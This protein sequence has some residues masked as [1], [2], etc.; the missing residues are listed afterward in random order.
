[1]GD[2]LHHQVLSAQALKVYLTSKPTDTSNRLQSNEQRIL[3]RSAILPAKA[4]FLDPCQKAFTLFPLEKE[5]LRAPIRRQRQMLY[6]NP[7]MGD[8]ESM[9]N[10][11]TYHWEYS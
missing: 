3:G 1:M 6:L 5:E 10:S 8:S 2:N 9:G 11:Q 4:V 7:L